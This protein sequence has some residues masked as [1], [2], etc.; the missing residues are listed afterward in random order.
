MKKEMNFM[1]NIAIDEHKKVVYHN[2]M[3]FDFTTLRVFNDKYNYL[4]REVQQYQ[5]S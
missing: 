4:G 2:F 3:A 5:N 1:D